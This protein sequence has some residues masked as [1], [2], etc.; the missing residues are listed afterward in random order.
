MSSIRGHVEASRLLVEAKADVN[1][2]DDWY[3]PSPHARLKMGAQVLFYLG[4]FNSLVLV[5]EPLRSIGLPVE[6]TSRLVDCSWRRKLTL[7]QK[8]TCTTAPLHARLK[9][10]AQVLF[11][12]G[13]FNS[14]VLVVETLRSI[15]L[16]LKVTSRFVDCSWRR[17]LT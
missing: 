14:L 6:V 8:T 12:F 17:K 4:R 15:C 3:N 5:V 2:K 13:R 1:A 7:T 16:P 9:M 11:Y 10:G